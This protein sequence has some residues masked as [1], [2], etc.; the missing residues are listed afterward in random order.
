MPRRARHQAGV[1]GNRTT[2]ENT[3]V[4]GRSPQSGA[5]CGV[6]GAREAPIDLDLAALLDAWP[7]LSLFVRESIVKLAQLAPKRPTKGVQP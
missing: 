5:E 7:T 6:L 1:D 2:P 4:I 3:G